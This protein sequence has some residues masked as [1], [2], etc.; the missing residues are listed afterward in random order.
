MC[1]RTKSQPTFAYCMCISATFVACT[2]VCIAVS[3]YTRCLRQISFWIL[4]F[5][6]AIV[7]RWRSSLRGNLRVCASRTL[8]PF[9]PSRVKHTF[10]PR[11]PLGPLRR[12]FRALLSRRVPIAWSVLSGFITSDTCKWNAFPWWCFMLMCMVTP[13]IPIKST[14][15]RRLE[16]RT[17][18]RNRKVRNVKATQ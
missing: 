3:V 6:I 5:F 11:R 18:M 1:G 7:A 8:S 9:Y 12:L 2:R 16:E 15:R 17:R 14:H 13:S 10:A 4:F